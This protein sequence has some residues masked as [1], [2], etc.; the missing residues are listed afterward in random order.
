MH[1]LLYHTFRYT[2]YS[3]AIVSGVSVVALNSTTAVRVSWTP[4]NLPSA[5]D[6][7]T[8]HYITVGG[9]R[10]TL[11]FPGITSLGVVSGLQGGQQYQ[12]SVTV[13][14]NVDGEFFTRSPN[15]TQYQLTGEKINFKNWYNYLSSLLIHLQYLFL[16]VPRQLSSC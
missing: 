15:Y 1:K 11:T 13:T 14:L 9:T 4:V 12:F 8:V 16:K 7:Y 2:L 10:G 3:S 6:H 5:V